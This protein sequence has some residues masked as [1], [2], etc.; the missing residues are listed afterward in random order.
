MPFAYAVAQGRPRF[1]PALLFA[2]LLPALLLTAA[3]D[4][5]A[6]GDLRPR[7]WLGIYSGDVGNLP[8]IEPGAGGCEALQGALSGLRVTAVSPDSPASRG[9]LLTGDILIAAQGIPFAFPAD[10][11][12]KLFLAEVGR[13]FDG[14]PFSVRVIRLAVDRELALDGLFVDQDKAA[15]FWRT[16]G[17]WLE[18]LESGQS[19]TAR[20][21]KRQQVLDLEITLG[22]RPEARWPA[23]PGNDEIYPPDRFKPSEWKPLVLRMAGEAAAGE[24]TQDLLE[25]L[26]R[27]HVTADPY[28]LDCMTYVHRDPFR[29]ESVSREILDGVHRASSAADYLEW[30]RQWLESASGR[31][32]FDSFSRS[33]AEVPPLPGHDSG[34]PQPKREPAEH[35]IFPDGVDAAGNVVPHMVRP[36]IHWIEHV[37]EG[38]RTWHA[39]AFRHLSEEEMTFL[40]ESIWDLGDV[41]AETIYIHFDD[42]SE[43]FARN[44]RILDLAARVDYAALFEAASWAARL[45]DPAW[46]RETAVLLRTAYEDRMEDA[47]LL[48][49]E[50]PFGKI[51]IAGGADNWHRDA[52]VAF[53]MDLG[54]NDLYTGNSGGSFGRSLPVSICLD[55]EGDDAYESTV[56]GFQGAGILGIGMMVDLEGDDQYIGPQWCQGT[57]YLGIGVLLDLEGDDVYRGRTFCQG[58]GL[59]GAG[60]LIDESGN[61]RYEGD[62]KVQAVGLARG[63]GLL[64]DRSGNDSYYAKGLYPTGYGDAG[65]FDAWSQGSAIGFR[66]LA[67]GGLAVLLD[68]GGSDRMEAG[69]FSQGGGYYYG[70]GILNARGDGDDVYIGSRYNQGFSAH[71]AVGAFLEDGGNDFYT[72]RQGVAQGLAWDESVTLF[73]DSAGDDTYEG[74]GSFSQGASAHNSITAF[75]DRGGRDRYVYRPG[76]ARAGG[77]DYHGGSSLSFF[78][79]EGGDEDSYSAPNSANNALRLSPEYGIFLDLPGSLMEMQE[80]RLPVKLRRIGEER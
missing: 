38:A 79:D 59:F 61:D 28:R 44:R 11:A 67:S 73:I 54:G 48:S 57:G 49:R 71:Q 76:Q 18:L 37:L 2:V 77:N 32:A 78:A 14:D 75:L 34:V 62:A 1:V 3:G 53:L 68:G 16:P 41:F 24:Q 21:E 43:R 5:G 60:L 58:V 64:L 15:G 39:R 25:R 4:G 17:E 10:S 55:V 23:P 22:A 12:R 33:E 9:G 52:E 56:N 8:E 6:S 50:T 36:I 74:G 26:A 45:A 19:L 72:T 70:L 20:A 27:C 65:I 47:I 63:L 69:N 46:I 40:E 42:D 80:D 29:L 31:E 35:G 66:T 13:L 7:G 51:L 30:S